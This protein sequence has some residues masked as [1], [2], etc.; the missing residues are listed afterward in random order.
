MFWLFGSLHLPAVTSAIPGLNSDLDVWHQP[1]VTSAS[2]RIVEEIVIV[3]FPQFQ[4]QIVEIVVAFS[5]ADS[6]AHWV[7]I[8]DFSLRFF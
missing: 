2:E 1:A 5:G 8:V 4:E 7:Q 6:A 3:S